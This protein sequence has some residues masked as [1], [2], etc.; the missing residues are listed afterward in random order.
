[1][2][3]STPFGASPPI[4]TEPLFG[5]TPAFGTTPSFGGS[6]TQPGAQPCAGGD[7]VEA[8]TGLYPFLDNELPATEYSVIQ[9]HLDACPPCLAAFGFERQL[10]TTVRVKL[11]SPIDCPTTLADRI[12]LA[13]SNEYLITDI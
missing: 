7:C 10:R 1:M 13:L 5:S 4:G 12:R 6:T 3:P 8:A 11:S 9:A 2:N